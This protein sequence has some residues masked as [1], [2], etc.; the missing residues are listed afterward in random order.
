[1]DM[2]VNFSSLGLPSDLQIRDLWKHQDCGEF[3][4]NLAVG[5]GRHGCAVFKAIPVKPVQT[6]FSPF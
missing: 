1:M 2:V 6:E 5:L 3:H 4:G